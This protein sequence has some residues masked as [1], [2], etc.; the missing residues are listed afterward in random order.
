MFE[1]RIMSIYIF[2]YPHMSS[3]PLVDIYSKTTSRGAQLILIVPK[4]TM[5]A[6]DLA[7]LQS[8]YS[9]DP[10]SI[11][12]H[13]DQVAAKGAEKFM[14][15]F[16]VNYGHKSIGDCGNILLAF[17]GVSM[18][19]AKAIQDSQLYNGQE[20]S[21]RYIDFSQQ[22]FLHFTEQNTLSTSDDGSQGA[23]IQQQRRQL[24]L[25][26]LPQVQEHLR[27]QYPFEPDM[28]EGTYNRALNARAFDIVRGLL[29]AGT[30]TSLARWSSIS[31]ASEHL[32]RLRCHA[33]AEVRE[34]AQETI[35]LLQEVYP[36]SFIRNIYPER[37][38]Y[39]TARYRDHYYLTEQTEEI[40]SMQLDTDKVKSYESLLI[41]RPKG[42]EPPYQIGECGVVSYSQLLD[43]ASYRDQQ[44]HRA[45]VQRMGL[46]TSKFGMH[47]WYLDNLPLAARQQAEQIISQQLQA[48]QSLDIDQ[49]QTQY[50][51]P[52]GMQIPTHLTGHIGKVIYF[53]E[54]R[55]Q[56]TV[57]PTLHHNAY[58]LAQYVE[59]KLNSILESNISL[60]VDP[61]VGGFSIKRGTQTIFKKDGQALGDK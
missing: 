48:I 11:I 42:I 57:H 35:A 3:N 38:A 25:D 33:L 17:E 56:K 40:V 50:Y 16:F 4:S 15:Q 37:E 43:F 1:D 51:L 28:N 41:D 53:V 14:E 46:I 6:Q 10:A 26:I 23:K 54:L 19:T 36:A 30:S 13:L 7:M 45:I 31:N 55:A 58:E 60:Y 9:R 29:P 44:R 12:G 39:K 32:S 61:D 47:P 5:S 49:F 34:T 59:K 22:P 52:M 18:L 24:Y 21:T 8:L 20:A 2:P 27:T